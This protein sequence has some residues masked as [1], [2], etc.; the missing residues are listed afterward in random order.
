MS[1]AGTALLRL[2]TWLSPGFPVGG[3]SYSHGLETAIT[4]GMVGNRETCQEWIANI[5]CRG[6]GRID[7][8]FLRAACRAMATGNEL[9][10]L[11]VVDDAAAF[12]ATAETA[13]ESEA[14]G[15]AFLAAVLAAWPEMRLAPLV[16]RLTAE[17]RPVPYSVAVGFAAASAGI[18]EIDATRAY[19]H[20]F[21][22]NL[23]S[24]AVRLIPLGQTDGLRIAAALE[25]LVLAVAVETE[26]LTPETVG[27]ATWMVD[28]TS[29]RHETQDVRLFRS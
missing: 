17:R 1:P 20:A 13:L 28:W 4:R 5:L 26:S 21:A 3:Y 12:R 29:A 22:A 7:A 16:A 9:L 24:A 2:M 18:A 14:Q 19:L 15:R 10:M 11:D 27:T 6:A 23:I 25:P 8:V